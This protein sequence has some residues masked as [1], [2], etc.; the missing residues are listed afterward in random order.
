MFPTPIV[1]IDHFNPNHPT[2]NS[3]IEWLFAASV[4]GVIDP[5][6]VEI[7]LKVTIPGLGATTITTRLDEALRAYWL[8]GINVTGP[9]PWQIISARN[10]Q[11][12][13]MLDL[14][15]FVSGTVNVGF[16]GEL[17]PGQCL[18]PPPP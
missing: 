1:C 9:Y 6:Q 18:P 5:T 14:V 17:N 15:G 2:S 7:T 4:L 8:L 13:Q 12:A 3:T 16:P 11:T 10:L